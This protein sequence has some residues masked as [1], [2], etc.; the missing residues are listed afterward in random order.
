M[1]QLVKRERRGRGREG[2]GEGIEDSL[3][4]CVFGCVF[5]CVHA[6]ACVR[7]CVCAKSTSSGKSFGW[8]EVKRI[9]ISGST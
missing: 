4:L 5:V 3:L 2:R 8:G 9:L 7:V 6:C 1:Q